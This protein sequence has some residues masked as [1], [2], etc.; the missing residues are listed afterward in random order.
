M[1]YKIA[2][3]GEAWGETESILKQPFVGQ[4]GQELNR[5]LADAGIDRAECFVTNV[6]NFQPKGNDI[7]TLCTGAKDPLRAP[8]LPPLSTGSY[9]KREYLS[10]LDRLHQEIRQATPNITVALG[11]TACWALL[12][13]SGIS[14][15]RGTTAISSLIPGTKVLPTY[16]PAAILR[17]WS[18][19]AVTVLDL[20]KAKRESA[21]PEIRRVRRQL[22]IDPTLEDLDA[23]YRDHITPAP[24]VVFDIETAVVR[25]KRQITNIGFAPSPL[26]ALNIPFFDARK[27]PG[28]SYWGSISDEIAAVHFIRRVF[29][30]G[31]T[32][33][34]QNG[35]Y[36][37]SWIWGVYGIPVPTFD[38]DTM[39][40]HHSL[41]PESPKALDFLGSVYAD[42]M[43]WKLLNKSE[44][45][46]RDS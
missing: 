30:N 40:L 13:S 2:L 21:Y 43:A 23:F 46:K 25:T 36:D 7:E 22:L 3:V 28:N 39:L 1:P 14:K 31:K 37:V 9:V 8:G 12:N 34:A 35:M 10:E 5:I 41:Q 16:H 17:Q 45:P 6:F 33:I 20:I 38:E 15:L 27:A 4:A 32:F 11:N 29:S 24:S 42:E 18:L 26:I 19:R 44:T